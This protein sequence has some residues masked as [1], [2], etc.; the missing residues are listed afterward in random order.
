MLKGFRAG[1]AVSGL[2]VVCG[3]SLAGPAVAETVDAETK[4]EAVTVYPRGAQ[5]VRT[6]KIKVPAGAHVLRLTG[7]PADIMASTFRVEG[8]G[9]AELEIGTVDLKRRVLTS[10]EQQEAAQARKKIE[11]EIERLE[12]ELLKINYQIKV[13]ETQRDFLVNL[14]GLPTRGPVAG[15]SS[16]TGSIADWEK[17]FS[18]IGSNMEGV[19]EAIF[20]LRQKV[21]ETEK[22]IED[23]R[24]KLSELAPQVTQGLNG[25]IN[26]VSASEQEVELT[27]RYQVRAASWSP[28]YDARL[29]TGE[30]KADAGLVLTRRAAVRQSTG[31]KWTNVVLTLSTVRPSGS[32]AAPTLPSQVV[33]FRPKEPP[34][35]RPFAEAA[36]PPQLKRRSFAGRLRSAPAGR[37]DAVT[38][39][40]QP[41]K[42]AMV[43]TERSA[44]VSATAFQA[45]FK[46][47]DRTS[48]GN[49]S[50][51][52]QIKID[53]QKI[54]PKLIHRTVP[55]L[56]PRAFLYA[57]FKLP[58]ETPFLAGRIALFRDGTYVGQGYL[59]SRSGGQDFK[60]GFGTDP[61]VRIKFTVSDD[62]RSQTGIISA[63]RVESKRHK[64]EV[65]NLHGRA[66][67][68][69]VIDRVPV[70][71][72]E[73]IVVEPAASI[74]PNNS[75]VDGRRGVVSWNLNL[76]AKAKQTMTVGYR[77]KW[78]ASK[79]IMYR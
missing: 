70:S 2:V 42:P 26:V 71:R 69:T 21:K 6:G 13:K 41:A 29:S 54:A 38:T 52:K 5:I 56:D 79:E 49:D 43:A 11:D 47:T 32:T 59:P 23:Q 67:A 51:V 77:I 58:G 3:V 36:P 7:L 16:P 61:K 57:T 12:Q 22:A 63:A 50:T 60:L 78:P 20:A 30:G 75:D 31:E 62:K 55:R 9:T 39:G 17:I 14:A 65:Q 37:S 45:T 35:P 24:R 46:L 8:R 53:T 48:V 44:T 1:A 4:I 40:A 66:I 68:I 15:N 73:E 33:D 10:A 76:A 19:Q 72:D 28:H 64:L 25:E 27:V 34:S 18:L 74:K